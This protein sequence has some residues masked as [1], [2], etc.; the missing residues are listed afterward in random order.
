LWEGV[1]PLSVHD[2]LHPLTDE[3]GAFTGV[4]SEAD[5]ACI[6]TAAAVSTAGPAGTITVHNARC[7]HASEPNVSGAA[8]P[9]LLNTFASASAGTLQAGTNGIHLR[10]TRGMPIVRGE[11]EVF[12]VFDGRPCPMAPDFSTGYRTPFIKKADAANWDG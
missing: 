1:V 4:L 9:L 8:R 3:D 12:T 2:E 11:A 7:V 6:D 10:S 5:L